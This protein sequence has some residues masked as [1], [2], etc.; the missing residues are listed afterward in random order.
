MVFFQKMLLHF[1]QKARMFRDFCLIFYFCSFL[2]ACIKKSN[3]SELLQ[4][5][6]SL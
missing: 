4:L 6:K 2:L 1:K 3:F 5:K